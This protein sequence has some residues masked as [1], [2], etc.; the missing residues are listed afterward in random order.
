MSFLIRAGSA[1]RAPLLEIC[2]TP[3]I[4]VILTEP[5]E[6]EKKVIVANIT[7]KRQNSDLT[8]ILSVYDYNELHHPSIVNYSD[9]FIASADKIMRGIESG[10]AEECPPIRRRVLDKICNGLSK[11]PY[12]PQ[13]V[14]KFYLKYKE[15]NPEEEV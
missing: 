3:H 7:S 1:Y 2:E 9:A 10:N 13:N 8:T 15:S 11:S 4:W 5:S 14:K 6:N 12:T